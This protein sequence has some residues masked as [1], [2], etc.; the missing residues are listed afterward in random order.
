MFHIH[1]EAPS[2]AF[3]CHARQDSSLAGQLSLAS[4][5]GWNRGARPFN[6]VTLLTLRSVPGRQMANA[7]VPQLKRR[8]GSLTATPPALLGL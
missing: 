4:P 8:P 5:A 6:T 7:R 3:G 2:A 1:W